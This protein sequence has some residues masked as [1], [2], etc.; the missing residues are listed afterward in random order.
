M[1]NPNKI[2]K[3]N[4]QYQFIVKSSDDRFYEVHWFTV[5]GWFYQNFAYLDNAEAWLKKLGQLYTYRG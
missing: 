4:N 2:I 5:G 1:R 3:Q